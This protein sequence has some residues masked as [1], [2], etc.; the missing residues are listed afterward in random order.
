MKEIEKLDLKKLTKGQKN[1]LDTLQIKDEY[2]QV[3]NP[4][5]GITV[6]LHPMAVALYDFIKGCEILGNYK[7]FDQARY[8]FVELWP[9][10]YMKLLD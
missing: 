10:E 4:F 6:T 1:F 8:I 5:S 9:D 2:E 7:K 3:T